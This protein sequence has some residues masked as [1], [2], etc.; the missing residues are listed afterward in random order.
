MAD[1]CAKMSGP[2]TS[3]PS[4]RVDALLHGRRGLHRPQHAT[5]RSGAAIPEK[6]VAEA[7]D[8][9]FLLTKHNPGLL[10]LSTPPAHCSVSFSFATPLPP[11]K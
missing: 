6:E 11:V 10:R 3:T 8:I 4:P 2:L 9:K 5:K 7:G 1:V